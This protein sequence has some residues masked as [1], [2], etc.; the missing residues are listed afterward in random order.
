MVTMT[1]TTKTTKSASKAP[2]TSIV[3][4]GKTIQFLGVYRVE[5]NARTAQAHSTT[6][7]WLVLGDV[8]DDGGVFWLVRP[9]E[10][11]R[12]IRAGYQAA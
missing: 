9:V 8:D 2:A 3:V 1:N 7:A 5:A 10:F 4:D 12:L 6:P 11:E